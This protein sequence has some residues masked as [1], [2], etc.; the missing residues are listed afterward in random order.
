VTT[1]PLRGDYVHG[2]GFNVNGIAAT[3]GGR[4]LVIVQSGTGKLFTVTTTGRTRAIALAEGQS[5]PNGD[6]ILLD[7]RTLYVVQNQ[8]NAIAKISLSAN[9]RSGRVLRRISSTSFDVPTTVAALGN[10]LY[11]VNARFGTT[12]SPSTPYSVVKVMR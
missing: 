2:S 3:D 9:L 7:G 10:H 8:L 12:P 4:T 11:A 1:V 6:G 5:V